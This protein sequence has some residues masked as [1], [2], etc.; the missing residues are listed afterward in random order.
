[1]KQIIQLD[2]FRREIGMFS[3]Q[4]REDI[5]SLIF[6]YL[7]NERLD[8]TDF[9]TYKTSKGTKIQEFK[10]KD[11]LGNWRAISCL[12]ESNYL[13]MVYAFHKKSQE[14]LERDREIIRNRIKGFHL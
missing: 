9:K 13:L 2:S 10:V 6:R 3:A 1:M 11:H 5:F 4:T 7:R 8:K 14:L 12:Y